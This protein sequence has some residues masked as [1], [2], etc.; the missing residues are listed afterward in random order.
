MNCKISATYRFEKELKKLAKKYPSLAADLRVLYKELQANPKIGTSLGRNCYK[1]RIAIKSKG[2]GKSGGGRV[3]TY[4]VE[5]RTD[6][7]NIFL[8]SIFDKS[9]ISTINDKELRE[10]IKQ[11]TKI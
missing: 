10:L 7:T 5:E 6:Q 2:K 4:V 1:I 9:D 11:A 8:L 3:I